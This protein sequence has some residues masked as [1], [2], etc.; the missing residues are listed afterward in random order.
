MLNKYYELQESV[1]TYGNLYFSDGKI[2]LCK[3]Y[4]NVSKSYTLQLKDSFYTLIVR[5]SE[6]NKLFKAI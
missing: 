5:E 4:N 1:Y 2:F 3:S 6:F